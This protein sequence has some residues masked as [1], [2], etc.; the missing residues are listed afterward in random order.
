MIRI[1][2]ALDRFHTDLGWL[3]SRHSFSF[4]EHH[5]PARTG[6]GALRVINEDVVAGGGGFPAHGHRDME[7]ISYV[8]DGALAH[9]DSTGGQG[10]IGPGMV[11]KMS[12]GKGVRHAEYNASD[13]APAHFLQIWLEPDVR[14]AAPKYEEATVPEGPGLR[15]IAAP[16]GAPLSL[17]ADARLFAARLDAGEQATAT[18]ADGRR[19][20]VQAARGAVTVNGVALEAGDGAALS[21]EAAVSLRAGGEGAEALLFDLA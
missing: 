8:L 4:G 18:L 19:A 20:W 3:D 11:Q 10:V 15:L 9:S 5:D 2:R 16:S 7:I 1:L 12:A 21:G 6:F 17:L 14:G 13:T